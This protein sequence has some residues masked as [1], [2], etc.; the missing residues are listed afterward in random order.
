LEAVGPVIRDDPFEFSAIGAT[1][2][3]ALST[4]VGP[5]EVPHCAIVQS[6]EQ[7]SLQYKFV[8]DFKE[9]VH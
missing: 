4:V 9:Y 8:N 5:V 7:Q 2:L 6:P 1:E 3:T